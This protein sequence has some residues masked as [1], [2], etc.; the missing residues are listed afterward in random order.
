MLEGSTS[1]PNVGGG[2]TPCNPTNTALGCSGT[3]TDTPVADRQ[4]PDPINPTASADN[5]FQS[6]VNQGDYKSHYV[7]FMLGVTTWF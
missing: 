1:N 7:M 5:Q 4:G 6:P 2:A 3:N